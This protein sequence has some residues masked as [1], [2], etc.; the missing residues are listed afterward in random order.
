GTFDTDID[1]E[2]EELD[3]AASQPTE[4][5]AGTTGDWRIQRPEVDM[6][7]CIDCGECVTYCPDDAFDNDISIDFDYCK[8]CGICANVCPVDAIEMEPEGGVAEAG[9]TQGAD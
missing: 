1:V 5:A 4:A 6:D 3:V 8:G 9:V 2:V 7:A